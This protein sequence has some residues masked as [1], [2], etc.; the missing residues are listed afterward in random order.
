MGDLEHHLNEIRSQGQTA[1]QGAFTLN[2]QRASE[3]LERYQLPDPSFYLLKFVQGAVLGGASFIRVALESDGLTFFHD[4]QESGAALSHLEIGLAAFQSWTAQAPRP[5]SRVGCR[6][7]LFPRQTR[8]FFFRR[9]LPEIALLKERGRYCSIPIWLENQLLNRP[10]FGLASKIEKKGIKADLSSPPRLGPVTWLTCP[11]WTA[12]SLLAPPS[13]SQERRI[14]LESLVEWKES[15][16]DPAPSSA[17]SV[18]GEPMVACHALLRR[19]SG[20]WSELTW[21]R[22]GVVLTTER[23][24][25]DRPGLEAVVSA[26][27]LQL[28]LSDFGLVH[29]EPFYEL[30]KRLRQEV[31]W[32]Y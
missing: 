28:D 31:L 7:F 20:S 25:L 30:T 22:D 2:Q 16:L 29:D 9:R 24:V 15:S 5:Q 6:G 17:F 21:V 26:G 13:Y 19:V 10:F 27:E 32:M 8:R 23:N 4:G 14:H 3:L 1:D 11:N 18:E 12:S